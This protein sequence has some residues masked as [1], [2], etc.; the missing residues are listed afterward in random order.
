[1]TT[2]NR[3][4]QP[5][6]P[7]PAAAAPGLPPDLTA[8]VTITRI[9]D[10]PRA[11]VFAAWTDPAQVA[12]W[13]S[14]HGFTTPLCELD[15]RPGGTIL[16]HMLGPDGIIYP[17][18][19]VYHEIVPPER[20]VFT[21]TAIEDEAGQ[22]QLE[23]RTTVTFAEYHGKTKLTLQAV[24]VRATPTVAG[25]LAGMAAGWSQSL[26]KL[27]EYLVTGDVTPQAPGFGTVFTT[28]SEQTL[29]LTRVFNAPRALV[30]KAVTDP[31][32]IAQWWGRR[33]STTTVD[34]MDLRPG[35]GW[36]FV[37]RDPDGSEEAF[38]GEYREIVPPER[39]V[40]TFE[41]EGLPGHVSVETLTLEEQDGQTRMTATSSFPTVE[42]RD[43]MI[44]S[45]MEEGARETWDRLAALVERG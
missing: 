22:P 5:P 12:Q 10:A 42:D 28:P 35:G 41:W 6:A 4:P 31:A 29:M 25:A 17:D 38:H 20:L 23:V 24:V 43:G 14:P 16:M 7:P 15:V 18:K 40:Q 13:W 21:S 1:M 36:R 2:A 37:T 11:R 32:L 8:P 27:A 33:H 44:A 34:Q 19:G 3:S 39:L 26:E 45:G 9:L 30:W